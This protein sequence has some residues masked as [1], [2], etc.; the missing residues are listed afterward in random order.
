MALP[1]HRKRGGDLTPVA[2]ATVVRIVV[3]GKELTRRQQQP[4]SKRDDICGF[5]SLAP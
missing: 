2:R 3:N 1:V 4:D 5:H